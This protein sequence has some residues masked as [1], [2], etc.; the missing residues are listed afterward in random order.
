[1]LRLGK[2]DLK[3]LEIIALGRSDA[4]DGV[5]G[6]KYLQVNFENELTCED[7]E[8]HMVRGE[9]NYFY[10]ALPPAQQELVIRYVSAVAHNGYEVK[11]LLEKPF[12]FSLSNAEHLRDVLDKSGIK[13]KTYLCDHYLFKENVLKLGKRDFKKLKIVV[14]EKDGVG[15]RMAYYDHV[16]ALRD[17]VQSHFLNVAFKLLDN[18]EIEFSSPAGGLDILKFRKEQYTEYKD[19]L[20]KE[21]KTE[22]F[23]DLEFTMAERD[24]RFVTGKKMSDREAY[25]EI[26][27]STTLGAGVERFDLDTGANPYEQVFTDFLSD[28]NNNNFAKL[29]NAIKAWQIIEKIEHSNITTNV[30]MS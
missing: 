18:P 25:I 26:D 1:M 14:L 17:M 16:G 29:D 21:S 2:P 28:K 7:C 24:Y 4:G 6:G 3:N 13:D 15:G 27:P 12:G 10:S 19:E 20:G 9:T 22:T 11:L 23:I 8:E 5:L 30:R